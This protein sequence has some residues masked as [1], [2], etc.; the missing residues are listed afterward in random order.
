MYAIPDFLFQDLMFE[1]DYFLTVFFTNMV[2]CLKFFLKTIITAYPFTFICNF[3]N[4]F[5]FSDLF[6]G[7]FESVSVFNMRHKNFVIPEFSF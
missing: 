5:F 1:E 4:T 7:I 2:N 3:I 6:H